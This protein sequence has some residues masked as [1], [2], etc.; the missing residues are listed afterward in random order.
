MLPA[1][2]KL[3]QGALKLRVVPVDKVSEHVYLGAWDVGAKLDGGNYSEAGQL[4]GGLEHLVEALG[5]VVIA[6]GYHFEA[7]VRA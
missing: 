2:P 4:A 1:V 7:S 6:H 3:R 5:G